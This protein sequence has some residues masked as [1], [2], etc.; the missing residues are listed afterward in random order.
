MLEISPTNVARFFYASEEKQEDREMEI[1]IENKIKRS[2]GKDKKF[3]RFCAIER[4][5]RLSF[6]EIL[7]R[8]ETVQHNSRALVTLK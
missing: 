5:F 4:M 7:T 8:K 1:G 6:H 2:N 3:K